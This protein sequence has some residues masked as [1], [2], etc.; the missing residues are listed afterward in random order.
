[1]FGT[2][3]CAAMGHGVPVHREFVALRGNGCG[4]GNGAGTETS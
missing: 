3:R 2:V 4:D 1:M